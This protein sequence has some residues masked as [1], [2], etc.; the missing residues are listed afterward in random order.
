MAYETGTREQIGALKAYYDN[1]AQIE[2]IKTLIN[3]VR[4]SMGLTQHQVR[5]LGGPPIEECVD[6]SYCI[7]KPHD[8]WCGSVAADLGCQTLDEKPETVPEPDEDPNQ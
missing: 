1:R 6:G 3:E 8:L 5:G 4:L 7:E 2:F